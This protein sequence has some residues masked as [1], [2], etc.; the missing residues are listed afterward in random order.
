MK[1]RGRLA[2]RVRD[3]QVGDSIIFHGNQYADEA[4]RS[5]KWGYQSDVLEIVKDT[6]KGKAILH[7]RVIN[8]WLNPV[9]LCA[10]IEIPEHEAER[11]GIVSKVVT[12]WDRQLQ[13]RSAK[14]T[15]FRGKGID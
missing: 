9:N 2:R 11:L 7:F 12:N 1:K 13:N 5:D 8:G 6:A 3:I 14:P 4:N 10:T 15:T